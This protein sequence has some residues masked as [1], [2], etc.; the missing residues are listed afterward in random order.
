[1]SFCSN[2]LSTGMATSTMILWD[3]VSIT[4]LTLTSRRIVE[5]IHRAK[6]AGARLRVGPELEITG[7]GW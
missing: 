3:T 2:G 7:Y 1:M 6:E 5:S 4:S